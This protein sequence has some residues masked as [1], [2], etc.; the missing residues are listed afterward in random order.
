MSAKGGDHGYVYYWNDF[1]WLDW[2]M[3]PAYKV[4]CKMLNV[5]VLHFSVKNLRT[6]K[7]HNGNETTFLVK[8]NMQLTT[9]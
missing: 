9:K 2:M 6:I 5:V 1:S 3:S 8:Q 7:D 4:S